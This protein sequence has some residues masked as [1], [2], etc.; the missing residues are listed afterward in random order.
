M[1][2]CLW[3]RLE[4]YVDRTM[5]TQPAGRDLSELP[6]PKPVKVFDCGSL[7]STAVYFEERFDRYGVVRVQEWPDGL[8]IWVGGEIAY[9]SYT[10]AAR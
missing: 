8:V 5:L 3:R 7:G 2:G 1:F 4:L 6:A 9:R 10:P